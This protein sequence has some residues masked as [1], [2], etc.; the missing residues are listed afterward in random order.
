MSRTTD[1]VCGG[2]SNATPNG[3]LFFSS[4]PDGVR[5]SNLYFSPS[6]RSGM[7]SSQTPVGTSSRIGCTRPSHPLKSPTTLTRSAFGAHTAK[8]TPVV[9]AE[10]DA[11]RAELL[12]RPVVRAFAEQMQIEVGEHAAVAV[13]IVDLDLMA[14][15]ER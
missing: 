12:E 13:R 1:A 7:N 9:G 14:V 2:V 8:C 10:A 15:G 4:A 6:A 11:V 5:I 3:S